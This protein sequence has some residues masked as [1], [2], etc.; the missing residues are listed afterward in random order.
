M[1][2]K[3]CSFCSAQAPVA[4]RI[5]P[6]CDTPFQ[7][8]AALQEK[9]SFQKKANTVDGV[10]KK[11]MHKVCQSC[12]EASPIATRV[13]KKCNT[14]FGKARSKSGLEACDSAVVGEVI[15]MKEWNMPP[16]GP[17]VEAKVV[18]VLHADGKYEGVEDEAKAKAGGQADSEAGVVDEDE[19][20]ES[21]RNAVAEQW[22]AQMLKTV[23]PLVQQEVLAAT[24][25]T[26]KKGIEAVKVMDEIFLSKGVHEKSMDVMRKYISRMRKN[27][28]IEE[29]VSLFFPL[30]MKHLKIE[31]PKPKA[32]ALL[33]QIKAVFA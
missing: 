33:A 16:L 13:C 8:R 22:L 23:P 28:G 30:E 17:V 3:C 20:E 5:C 6:S 31:G 21:F 2:T 14:P 24:A 29:T 12:S 10:F 19:D 4:C 18:G 25:L 7:K 27:Y 9:T 1:P 32:V 26:H 15:A 11:R